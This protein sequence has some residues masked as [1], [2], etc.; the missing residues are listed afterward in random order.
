MYIKNTWNLKR[1]IQVE[2]VYSGRYGKRIPHEKKR[3]P[4]PEDVKRINERNLVKKLQ[5]LILC[6]FEEGDYHI[7]L[8]YRD[9]NRPDE[10]G[11]NKELKKFISKLQRWY[12]KQG[13]ELKYIKVTEKGK[14]KIHHHILIN[15]IEGCLKKIREIWKGG[16]Y[17]SI[18]YGEGNFEQLADYL[19]KE[20]KKARKEGGE[21]AYSPS[22]NLEKPVKKTEIIKAE[23]WVEIPVPP[24]GY[25]IPKSSLR[26]GISEITGRGYQ[27]YTMIPIRLIQDA[28]GEYYKPKNYKRRRGPCVSESKT[29]K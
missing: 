3:N 12:K 21:L 5:R 18:M 6:N 26:C 8:T 29:K 10:E 20:T 25:W 9:E 27:Y 11:A 13:S 4:T 19:V 23:S 24:K 15:Q 7:T 14:K 16:I 17:P 28:E 22:R 1:V 2:K